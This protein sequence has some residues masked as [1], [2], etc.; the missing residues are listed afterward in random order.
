MLQPRRISEWRSTLN[1]NQ[2]WYKESQRVE[3]Y[4]ECQIRIATKT[5]KEWRSTLNVVV[6]R[7]VAVAVFLEQT[8]CIV[9]GEVFKLY[10]SALTIPT[11]SVPTLNSALHPSGVAISTSVGC[12]EGGEVTAASMWIHWA[13]SHQTAV[14]NLV[15]S[16]NIIYIRSF[17]KHIFQ[18]N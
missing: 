5:V 13:G 3:I 1:V 6:K 17:I 11:N 16:S 9:V 4:P 18:V 10:Q 8:K 14:S 15:F 12:G 2:N 7:Q